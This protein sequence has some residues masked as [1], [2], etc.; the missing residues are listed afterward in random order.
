MHAFIQY[1]QSYLDS[2]LTPGGAGNVAINMASLGAEVYVVGLV[3]E[4]SSADH[5][6]SLLERAP[7]AGDHLGAAR[8]ALGGGGKKWA[9]ARR[10]R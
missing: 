8:R 4:D 10:R 9:H 2:D 7:I 5:L 1:I 3:G 6:M